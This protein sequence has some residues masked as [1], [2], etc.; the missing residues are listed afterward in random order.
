MAGIPRAAHHRQPPQGGPLI[1]VGLGQGFGQPLIQAS[2][3][4]GHM[5]PGNY[6]STAPPP[7]PPLGVM[8][9]AA[10]PNPFSLADLDARLR[11]DIEDDTSHST[12][13][14]LSRGGG[15]NSSFGGLYPPRGPDMCKIRQGTGM[16]DSLVGI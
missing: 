7:G 6:L 11:F 16:K 9:Q 13:L 10:P 8:Q 12:P 2:S 1:G 14:V 4:G 15:R 3:G 5:T